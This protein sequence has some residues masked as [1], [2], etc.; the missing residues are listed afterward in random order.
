[1]R[2][3]F[4]CRRCQ[5]PYRSLGNI[6]GKCHVQ[7]PVYVKRDTSVAACEVCIGELSLPCARRSS[8]AP[9]KGGHWQHSSPLAWL[10]SPTAMPLSSAAITSRAKALLASWPAYISASTDQTPPS[11]TIIV[12]V[13]GQLK[14]YLPQPS[15]HI[16]VVF[17]R[18]MQSHSV[19]PCTRRLLHPL[20][21]NTCAC[22]RHTI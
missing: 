3:Y 7:V 2:T 13:S 5:Y 16:D 10:W 6:P 1:M 9:R 21:S 15:R 18:D 14:V 4:F 11:W 17:R 19:T 12:S 22:K 8:Q 20:M